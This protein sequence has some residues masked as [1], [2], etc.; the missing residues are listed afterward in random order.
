[1]RTSGRPAPRSSAA[2]ASAERSTC[3]WSNP[4]ERDPGD[5]HEALQVGADAGEFPL[6]RGAQVGFGER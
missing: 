1:M 6:D 2:T 5:A 3:E 4:L